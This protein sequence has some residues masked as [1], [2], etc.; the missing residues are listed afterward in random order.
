MLPIGADG[1]ISED[2]TYKP[3]NRE[4]LDRLK[5]T[6]GLDCDKEKMSDAV[7]STAFKPVSGRESIR[8]Q[9]PPAEPNLALATLD[10][11]TSL[12]DFV[13]WIALANHVDSTATTY[14]LAISVSVL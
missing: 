4:R 12:T 8:Q 14:D 11:G 7:F 9:I 10:L 5:T 6:A 13:A 2:R 3:V 1:K